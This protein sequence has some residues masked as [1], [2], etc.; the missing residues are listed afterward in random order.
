M[1]I[2]ILYL[3]VINADSF[4]V[5]TDSG[6]Y[7]SICSY[8][9]SDEE[10]YVAHYKGHT[11]VSPYQCPDCSATFDRQ[12]QLSAHLASEHSSAKL[13]EETEV[14]LDDVR[15]TKI[16]VTTPTKIQVNRPKTSSTNSDSTPDNDTGTKT[17]TPGP[18]SRKTAAARKMHSEE[19]ESSEPMEVEEVPSAPASPAEDES[20][21]N[22]KD[23]QQRVPP[24]VYQGDLSSLFPTL[25][26]VSAPGGIEALDDI[27]GGMGLD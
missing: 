27:D 26:G 21:T 4:D 8:K 25:G 3:M 9:T 17:Y 12:Q 16:S 11:G 18:A 14:T 1:L 24:S 15:E 19:Q 20:D 22:N 23:S 7:C 13:L 10:E 5:I 2:L 6:F